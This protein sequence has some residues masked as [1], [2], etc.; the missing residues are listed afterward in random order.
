MT[1]NPKL[2]ANDPVVIAALQAEGIVPK[3]SKPKNTKTIQP[4]T[5]DAETEEL[6]DVVSKPT[7]V[8]ITLAPAEV[9]A[10]EREARVKGVSWKEYLNQMVN[11]MLQQRVGKALI[12]SPSWAKKVSA[13]ELYK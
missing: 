5:P 4:S 13:P 3:T 1:M 2:D 10:L 8:S 12:S 9:M 7:R 11:E 6:L